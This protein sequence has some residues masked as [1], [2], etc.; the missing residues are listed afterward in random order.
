MNIEKATKNDLDEILALQKIAYLSEAKL[1]EDFNIQPLIQT[2]A[3]I[4]QEYKTSTILK[5]T[6]YSNNSI[7]GSVRGQIDNNTV[8]IGKLIVHP[9]VQNQGIGTKL[10]YAIEQLYPNMRYELFTSS[11]S[12]KNLSLYQK[13]GYKIFDYK[14]LN[15]KVNLVFLEK[16]EVTQN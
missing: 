9:D 8:Y 15:N 10:L 12:I 14:K 5:V 7:I 16:T 1:L 3:E 11:L 6:D 13:N 4:E 2:I